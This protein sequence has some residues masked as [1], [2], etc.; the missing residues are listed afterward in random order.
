MTLRRDLQGRCLHEDEGGDYARHSGG[1]S[2]NED[3]D[4]EV[5]C[6]YGNQEESLEWGKEGDSKVSLNAAEQ[7]NRCGDHDAVSQSIHTKWK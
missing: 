6:F 7:R 1:A 3:G 4:E 5:H 2:N